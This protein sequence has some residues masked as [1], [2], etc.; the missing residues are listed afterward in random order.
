MGATWKLSCDLLTKYRDRSPHSVIERADA[1][2]V[3]REILRSSAQ[4]RVW[5]LGRMPLCAKSLPLD[6]SFD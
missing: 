3:R 5:R 6:P 2:T 4:L 1:G